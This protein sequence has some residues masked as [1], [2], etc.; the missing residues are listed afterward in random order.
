MHRDLPL[1][2]P[3]L[4]LSIVVNA[5]ADDASRDNGDDVEGKWSRMVET[6]NGPVTIIKT[7][8]DGTTTL[9]MFDEAGN[10]LAGKTSDYELTETENVR[11]FTFSNNIVT[12]GPGAGE[13]SPTESAY[14][15][16]IEDHRFI[17]VRGLI[18]GQD[19][20]FGVVIWE[21]VEE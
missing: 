1:Y 20:P 4:I 6:E 9:E 13:I 18:K 15:Y 8:G 3:T 11:I 2:L 17:E 16:R 10:L 21:R 7:H 12:A 5:G 14:V 19:E